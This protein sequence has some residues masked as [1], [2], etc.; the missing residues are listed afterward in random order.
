MTINLAVI[1]LTFLL[2][3]SLSFLIQSVHASTI[4][5][6]GTNELVNRSEL[7][8]EGTVISVESELNEFGRVYTYV[9]F[10]IEDIL[11]GSTD[12]AETLTLRFTGGSVA[13]VELDLGVEIPKIDERGIYFVEKVA[14]GLINPLL[15]WE[16]G[17]FKITDSGAVVA[18]NSL[19]VE[20]IELRSKSVRP[21][22]SRGVA[23]GIYTRPIDEITSNRDLSSPPM[24]VSDF[25]ERIRE[26]LN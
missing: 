21:S 16:Q 12:Y 11:V 2:T 23:L 18:A 10:V 19:Q 7:V 24:S 20:N 8:F 13:G 9:V 26:L 25:K 5:Q 3:A 14:Y 17:H 6:I 15:G 1:R 4:A 22:T